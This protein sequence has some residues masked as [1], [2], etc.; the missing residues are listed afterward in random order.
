M[1]RLSGA[2]LR[3]ITLGLVALLS[4]QAHACD[5]DDCQLSAGMHRVGESTAPLGQLGWMSHDLALVREAV[6]EGQHARA[7]DLANDLDR[8]LR[9]KLPSLRRHHDEHGI[10]S[11][12]QVLAALVIR[13]GGVP[14]APLPTTRAPA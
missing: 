9:Q 1:P 14:L 2:L 12:H 13:C 7:L 11:F 6:Y 8:A 5:L 4:P 3:A 10:R